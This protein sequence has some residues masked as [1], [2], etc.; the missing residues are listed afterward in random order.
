MNNRKICVITGTRAEY[1]L[2]KPVLRKIQETHGLELQLVVTGMHLLEAHGNT[3]KDIEADGF[4]IDKK[5]EMYSPGIQQKHQ[6]SPEK[7]ALIKGK[8]GFDEAFSELKPDMVLLLGD[9][10]EPFAAVQ[11]AGDKRIAI[12]HIH[13]GDKSSHDYIHIDEIIRH[14]IT[15]S[16]HIHFPATELS[17]SRIADLGEDEWRI[18]VTGSPAVDNLRE[19]NPV[20]RNVVCPK[21]G[22]LEDSSFLICIQHPTSFENDKA[23][24]FMRKT[25]DA[26]VRQNMPALIMYPNNDSGSSNVISV[27]EEYKNNPLFKIHRNIPHNDFISL[28][29]YCSAIVGNSTA[30]IIEASFL[31]TPAVNIG[32]RNEFREPGGNVIPVKEYDTEKIQAAIEKA[33]NDKE[34]RAMVSKSVSP[35][36]DGHAAEKIVKV[37]KEVK[38]DDKLFYKQ[39]K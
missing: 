2:L 8:K 13:G 37:L 33:V 38:L 15:K 1:G 7:L 31:K 22:L 9:R 36:G 21:Y 28:L 10:L 20:P 4:K 12:A 35:Y 24:M 5:F 27:I 30:G 34:F 14:K 23:G 17:K 25:L 3:Y 11:A 32:P 6:P 26:I 18:T 39:V 29:K 16:A 19:F